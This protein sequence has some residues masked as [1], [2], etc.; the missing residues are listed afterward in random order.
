M[1]IEFMKSDICHDWIGEFNIVQSR[2]QGFGYTYT[3]GSVGTH[4]YP[5]L[6]DFG[7]VGI[8]ADTRYA[9]ATH[10]L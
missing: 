2:G 1:R 6:A 8:S 4:E 5:A 7:C 10:Q 9:P 3:V